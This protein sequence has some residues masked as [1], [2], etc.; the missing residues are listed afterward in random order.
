MRNFYLYF[1]FACLH[2][3]YI[4]QGRK[5]IF[6]HFPCHV[7][8]LLQPM[9]T[10]R[11]RTPPRLGGVVCII[12]RVCRMASLLFQLTVVSF[13]PSDYYWPLR[14][15]T[16]RPRMKLFTKQNGFWVLQS[17]YYRFVPKCSQVWQ[18]TVVLKYQLVI[19]RLMV[20][21]GPFVHLLDF[22]RFIYSESSC[23]CSA[24]AP[25]YRKHT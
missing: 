14:F 13:S 23:R 16:V 1:L 9:S 22:F 12:G 19:Q 4:T 2:L 18:I 10:A 20:S 17:L 6:F 24:Y 5:I 21:F 15:R 7:V 8:I 11:Q 25:V 3:F